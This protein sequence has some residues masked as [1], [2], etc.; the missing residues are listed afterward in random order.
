MND[1][2][3]TPTACSLLPNASV[4]PLELAGA[5]VTQKF[6]RHCYCLVPCLLMLL[7]MLLMMMMIM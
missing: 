7:L 2:M 4:A 6:T 3:C 1:C 5:V